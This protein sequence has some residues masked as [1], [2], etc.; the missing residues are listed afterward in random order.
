[1]SVQLPSRL[2]LIAT[3]AR[4]ELMDCI[5]N[6]W[7]LVIF[8]LF[9]LMSLSVSFTGSVVTGSLAIPPLNSVIT[10][11]STLSVFIIPLAAIMLSYDAFVG[12][13]EAGTMLLLLSLPINRTDLLLGK[14]VAHGGVLSVA[15]MQSFML[16]AGLLLAFSDSYQ[17]APTFTAFAMLALSSS[18]LAITYSLMSFVVSLIFTEKAKVIASL[19]I[20]WFCFAMIY[21][22]VLLTLLVADAGAM[23][24][25]LVNVMMLLN[26]TDLYRA[27]NL[28]NIDT[29][30]SLMQRLPLFNWHVG[31]L[32]GM[33]LVWPIVLSGIAK[34]LFNRKAL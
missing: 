1:M 33:L 34:R 3:V 26:P 32:V 9:T 6:R 20:I 17:L 28:V 25:W 4:K 19:L 2:G 30:G 27:I 23:S 10:S 18:L 5:R 31:V 12:E 11:L 22:L 24:Q 7:L 8:C 16:C 13:E 15:I 14:L 21:D 29:S